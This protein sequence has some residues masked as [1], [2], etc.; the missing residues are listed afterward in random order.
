[1][2]VISTPADVRLDITK[3]S[4]LKRS[5]P[6]DIVDEPLGKRARADSVHSDSSSGEH[7]DF[8]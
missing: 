7:V 8:P 5:H 2:E 1:M 6:N 4:G 3:S